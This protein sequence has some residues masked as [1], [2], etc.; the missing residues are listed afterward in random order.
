MQG[1][2]G[3]EAGLGVEES[4]QAVVPVQHLKCDTDPQE[5]WWSV[6]SPRAPKV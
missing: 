1:F 6:Q 5:K 3:N 2:N 4:R